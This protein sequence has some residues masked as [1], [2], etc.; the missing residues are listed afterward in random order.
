MNIIF[1]G[2]DKRQPVAYNVLQHS[3][4]KRASKPININPLVLDWMPT[5][6]RGL[7]DF[8]H[9]RF[10]APWICNYNGWSLF[11]DADMLCLGDITEVFNMADD[12][13]SVMVVKNERK[14]EWPSLMLFN[15]AKCNILTPEFVENNN[16][17]K[18]DWVKE[19]EIGSL[20]EEWNHLVGYD[21]INPNP[22]L[23]HFTQGIPDQP[24][25]MNDEHA[26]KW[27]AERRDLF[28]TIGWHEIMGASV[29]A[30]HREQ[31]LSEIKEVKFKPIKSD[32]DLVK[33]ININMQRKLPELNQI[34]HSF[35]VSEKQK[36]AILC[37][38]G[39]SLKDHIDELK[40]DISTGEY[41]VYSV[42]G[43]H[44][45]LIDHG[46]IPTGHFDCD[47]RPEKSRTIMKP[48]KATNYYLASSSDPSY[49]DA[50]SGYN[51]YIW[52]LLF[53]GIWNSV[54]EAK[55]AIA[56]GSNIG[57]TALSLL[58]VLGY[59][60][61]K[62]YGLDCSFTNGKQYASENVSKEHKKINV[63]L[64][65]RWYETS[66]AMAGACKEFFTVMS[67]MKDCNLHLVGDGLLRNYVEANIGE[68]NV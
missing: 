21:K 35:M 45:F 55:S 46:I 58:K 10:L 27:L 52:H 6:K 64:K 20:P 43:A 29:H 17:L 33:N 8:T 47:P 15:N 51:I 16:C 57:M 2:F 53:D 66:M 7:T 28:R 36:K 40:F 11:L 65:D 26:D 3:L 18:M 5:Q 44:D 41:N 49:F 4:I 54:P 22:K 12:K 24:E 30:S 25:T 14:F 37:A 23:I 67:Y 50:L 34:S 56:G 60:D 32:E 38:S 68:N 1:I 19:E 42:A 39:V 9:S 31:K 62:I 13:Y 48:N 59:R 61:I 63:K